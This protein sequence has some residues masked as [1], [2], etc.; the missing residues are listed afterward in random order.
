MY[1]PTKLTWQEVNAF[2]DAIGGLS[3]FEKR[4]IIEMSQRYASMLTTGKDVREAPPYERDDVEY[5]KAK[6]AAIEAM[7]DE[8][9]KA[10]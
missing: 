10:P 4:C 2:S 3:L 6:H 5:I 7:V 9:S 1:G 8:S